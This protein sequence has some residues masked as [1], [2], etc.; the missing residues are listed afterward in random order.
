MSSIQHF[1]LWGWR[2]TMGVAG[3]GWNF[4]CSAFWAVWTPI[5][6]W[7]ITHFAVTLHSYNALCKLTWCITFSALLCTTVKGHSSE[8][9]RTFLTASCLKVKVIAATDRAVAPLKFIHQNAPPQKFLAVIVACSSAL[10]SYS[11]TKKLPANTWRCEFLCKPSLRLFTDMTDRDYSGLAPILYSCGF[12][13]TP[14]LS[15]SF[16]WQDITSHGFPRDNQYVC[17]LS[18]RFS[19]KVQPPT[20]KQSAH[21]RTCCKTNLVHHGSSG[22]ETALP[23]ISLRAFNS[24]WLNWFNPSC[25]N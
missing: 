17:V 4:D 22:Q 12:P 10:T 16:Y 20:Q 25:F 23:I 6:T 7:Y 19:F 2:I 15:S 13:C 21:A 8:E 5:S 24:D 18:G 14:F 11:C 3:A 1:R 9:C